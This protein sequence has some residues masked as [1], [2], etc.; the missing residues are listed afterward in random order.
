MGLY[1]DGLSLIIVYRVI[2]NRFDLMLFLV[3][4]GLNDTLLCT[5]KQNKTKTA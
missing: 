4:E 5:N 1:V 3:I 2:L